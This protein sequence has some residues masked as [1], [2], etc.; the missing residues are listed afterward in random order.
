MPADC[1]PARLPGFGRASRLARNTLTVLVFSGVGRGIAVG[2]E[3]LV[4]ALFG[5]GGL[6][7]AYVLAFL[8]PSVLV[9]VLGASF[10]S[11]LV[12]ALGGRDA[13]AQGGARVLLA[14][15]L[16]V[17]ALCLALACLLLW[18]LPAG[19][20]KLIA[21]ALTPERLALVKAMQT[22]LLPVL[23]LGG[24]SQTLAA[25]VNYRGGF[26]GPALATTLGAVATVTVI[27]LAHGPLGV[28][29]IVAGVDAGAALE[30]ALLALMAR[31]AW[32]QDEPPQGPRSR[33]AAPAL[34]PVLRDWSLLALGASMLAASSFVDNAIAST[35]GEGAVSALNYAWKLP[36][37]FATLLGLTLS[38]VLLPYF[39]G[40][41]H[42][43]P[44]GEMRRACRSIAARLLLACAPLAVAGALA[45]PW[46]VE[47]VFQRGR[48]DAAAA[49]LVAQAQA[50]YFVQLPFY[51]LSIATGRMLQALGRFRFLLL[52]QAGLVVV[53]ALASL[54]LSRVLGVA[55]LA[56]SSAIMYA[57]CAAGSLAAVR[58]GLRERERVR[59]A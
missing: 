19:A 31:R 6:L 51:L 10:A 39:T 16:P 55:G 48:F 43:A 8:V 44:A 5:V 35:L 46:L 2:K 25:S 15:A 23:A 36:S 38:T 34:P 47:L 42:N 3:M 41:A 49:G 22:S 11:A 24:I 17:Q 4:A 9:N 37:G 54:A 40:L 45:S 32:A 56:L 1:R 12:P 30:C 29:A 28:E 18:L 33:I 27:A 21:P 53:N 14:R 50:C 52:L 59:G 58:R 7:D 57:L 13:D 20:L 26:Q